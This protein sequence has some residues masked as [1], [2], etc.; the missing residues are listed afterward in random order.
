MSKKIVP[1]V[2]N[3]SGEG[4][5]ILPLQKDNIKKQ[6][7]PSKRWV[8]TY[9]NYTESEYEELINI[10]SSNSSTYIIG[11]EIGE[12][13]T[14]HLQGYCEFERKIRPLSAIKNNKIHW[15]KARGNREENLKYCSKDNNYI[16]NFK[17]QK[18]IK[19]IENLYE[20]QK[21]ILD[22]LLGEPNDRHIYWLWD[23]IG[24]VGKS[25]FCKY[26]VVH[27]DALCVDGKAND[28]FNGIVNYKEEKGYYPEIIL[29]DCPRHNIGFMN[30]G[31]LEKVKNG[32]VFSGKYESRQIVFNCPHVVVF[33]NSEPDY[34]MYSNDRWIVYDVTI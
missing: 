4:N 27:H 25:A 17:L 9:N 21:G 24:N 10:L 12:S 1:I 6:I 16:T 29:V 31:A 2:P 5:T 15:E 23:E 28:I 26:M 7:S 34:S 20:W 33:A 11:K 22:V 14:S 30:Y 18:P 8:F 19:T 3:S 32:L 13:G